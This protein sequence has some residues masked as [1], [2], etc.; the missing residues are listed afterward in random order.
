MSEMATTG[1]VS[2]ERDGDYVSIKTTHTDLHFKE[3]DAYNLAM[4]L[5]DVCAAGDSE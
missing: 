4:K 5:I 3:P 2:V 1:T